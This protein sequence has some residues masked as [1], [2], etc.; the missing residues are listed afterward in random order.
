MVFDLYFSVPFK[1]HF[2]QAVS[3]YVGYLDPQTQY[4]SKNNPQTLFFSL[5]FGPIHGF[6]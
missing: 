4:Q 6:G 1:H 5:G 2:V 3:Q